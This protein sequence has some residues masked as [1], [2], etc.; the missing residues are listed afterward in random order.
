MRIILLLCFLIV[1]TA[2]KAQI[3]P[4]H[5]NNFKPGYYYTNDG[6]KVKGKI[7]KSAEIF[8]ASEDDKYLLFKTDTGKRQVDFGDIKSFVIG[9]DSFTVSHKNRIAYKVE[10]NSPYKLYSYVVIGSYYSPGIMG[11]NGMMMGGGTTSSKSVVYFYGETPDS[12]VLIKRKNFMDAMNLVLATKPNVLAKVKDKTYTLGWMDEIIEF[13]N[14][15]QEPQK[16][17]LFKGK[18]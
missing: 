14:T 8:S 13:Y 11:A 18:N 3:G 4:F 17:V 16:T 7:E 9:T 6:Q 5:I 10:L 1:T 15:N 12:V 2:V